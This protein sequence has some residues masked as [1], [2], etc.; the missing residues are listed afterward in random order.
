MAASE[1]RLNGSPDDGL[2]EPSLVWDKFSIYQQVRVQAVSFHVGEKPEF[3]LVVQHFKNPIRQALWY[4]QLL[5]EGRFSTQ[6]EL[7]QAFGVSRSR[8][9]SVLRL[10]KLDPEIREYMVGLAETDRRLG[11]LTERRLRP[12]VQ[13]SEE[14]E[15][16]S[17]FWQ[18]VQDA[19]S[20]VKTNG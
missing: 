4:K 16:C 14:K 11:S 12:V 8:V 3:E 19:L 18:M 1:A 9:A 10:L 7:A 5:D 6:G 20:K 2:T 17:R 15:Q 13:M